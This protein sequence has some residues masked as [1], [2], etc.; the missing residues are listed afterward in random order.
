MK[1]S[2]QNLCAS[3]GD[4]AIS[5]YSL[6]PFGQIGLIIRSH[7]ESCYCFVFLE[8]FEF[9]SCRNVVHSREHLWAI[10]LFEETLCWL[11]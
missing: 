6:S 3:V 2:T 10:T 8:M 4:P 5:C 1:W 9:D 7:P 11:Q